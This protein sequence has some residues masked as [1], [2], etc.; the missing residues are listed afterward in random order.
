MFIIF[1][2]ALESQGSTSDCDSASRAFEPS[3]W[4][5]GKPSSR[6]TWSR[7]WKRDAWIRALS[8]RMFT[9]FHGRISHEWWTLFL[10]EYRANHSP[11]LEVARVSRT[12]VTS[13]PPSERESGLFDPESSSLKTSTESPPP[14]HPDT[15]QFSTMCSQTWKQWV[16]ARRRIALQRAKSPHPISE[17][18]GS[19]LRWPTATVGDSRNSARHSTTTGVMHAGTTLVD[20][21]RQWPTATAR[22]W[23]DSPGMSFDRPDPRAAEDLIKI[24]RGSNGRIDLLPRA[25]YADGLQDQ[26]N[27]STNGKSLGLLNPDWVE[28][29]MDFQVGWTREQLE[30]STGSEP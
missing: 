1:P 20:A 22:D 29:L 2:F 16:S 26:G 18:G 23:K 14:P 10:E 9:G 8:T 11:T 17:S 12:S 15:T 25:V 5:R 6:A 19:F 24:E 4:W 27:S 30:E 21:V 13:G 3:L 7:R 28:Q